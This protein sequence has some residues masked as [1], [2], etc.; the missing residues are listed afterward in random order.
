MERL[1][2]AG[3]RAG[4]LLSPILPGI[5]DSRESIEA[6]AISAAE[7]RA[8]FF[9]ASALRLA[10]FV[11][12]HYLGFVGATFPALLPR[13]QRAYAGTHA[14]REYLAAL[15]ARVD[16]IRARFGFAEDSMRYR[17]VV[18]TGDGGAAV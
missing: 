8:A 12:E 2:R 15:D 6:V 4:V 13:Y 9:G 7:H 3:V 1:T 17:R 16:D 10:P 18:Q 11:K 5:T 14:T